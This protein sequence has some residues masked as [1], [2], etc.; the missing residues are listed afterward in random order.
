MT[1]APP[2]RTPTLERA[3]G[4]RG[5]LRPAWLASW[6]V[7]MALPVVVAIWTDR[8]YVIDLTSHLLPWIAAAWLGVGALLIAA[9]RPAR[10]GAPAGIT[11]V[12]CGVLVLIA[13]RAAV[14]APTGEGPPAPGST[15]VKIV[16][17]NAQQGMTRADNAFTTWLRDQDPDLVVLN[18]APWGWRTESA[19]TQSQYPFYVE[20]EP[21]MEWPVILLSKWPAKV[22]PLVPYSEA[23]KFSFVSRRSL[24]VDLPNGGQ[25]LLSRQ[26]P[27]SPRRAQTWE[28]SLRDSALDAGL[29]RDWH[30]RTG[31]PV[32]V[33]GDYNS[34]PQGR[35]HRRFA[36]QS[37]LVG[38]SGWWWNAGT[39][40]SRL[41]RWLSVPI[42][43]VFTSPGVVV[44]RLEV[45]PAFR[46]DHRPIVIEIDVPGVPG[47][48]TT[49]KSAP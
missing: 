7:L 11:S 37:G 21:G 8:P 12:V 4:P 47:W 33:P 38:W 48:P 15:R 26:H 22:E 41:P 46:S 40:P 17:F 10:L 1:H 35:L 2:S 3:T 31:I 19:W 20:P 36:S 29:L 28:M 34:T 43:R 32:V 9:R 6:G 39:W 23:T 42:D 30:A 24:L 44:R 18:D 14:R 25:L 27:A 13:C 45:G 5:R 16:H 49:E